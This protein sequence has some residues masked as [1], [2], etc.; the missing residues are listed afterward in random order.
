MTSPKLTLISFDRCPYVQRPAIVLLEK[1]VPFER[2]YVDLANKPDWVLAISPFGKVPLLQVGEQVLFES[3]PICEYL[4]EVYAP[5]LYPA[6]PIQKARDRAWLDN[7]SLLFADLW[8]VQ[9]SAD[10]IA[11]EARLA[12]IRKTLTMFEA[13]IGQGPFFRGAEFRLVDAAIAP[14]FRVLDE[15]EALVPLGA[16]DGL[17]KVQAW[18]TALAARP[19]VRDAVLPNLPERLKEFWQEKA[20]VLAKRAGL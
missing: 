12:S 5:H 18:R 20:G 3:M 11:F 13:E 14:A 8:V 17:P 19:S 16:G 7:A 15:A 10:E 1:G 4:E 9:T 2:I 6:D